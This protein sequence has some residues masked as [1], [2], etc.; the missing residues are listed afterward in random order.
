VERV[1]ASD[2]LERLDSGRHCYGSA[3]FIVLRTWPLE[4]Q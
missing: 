3:S 2:G 4:R 1:R